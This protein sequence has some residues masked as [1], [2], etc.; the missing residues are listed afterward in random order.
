MT[1]KSDRLE[2]LLNDPDLKEGF[3]NVR[4]HYKNAM[5]MTPLDENGDKITLKLRTMLH[6]LDEVEQDL[7]TAL[8]DGQ[9]EDF[10][11]AEQERQSLIGKALD[12]FR[13]H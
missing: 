6:L 10:N 11:A 3:E 9:L 1:A 2:K 8:Q 12:G 4:E 7:Y 5:C 13:K